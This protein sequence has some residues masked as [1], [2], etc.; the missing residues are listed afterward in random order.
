MYKQ[1]LTLCL[2]GAAFAA[3]GCGP[4]NPGVNTNTNV[5]T[6]VKLDPANMPP[7]LSATPITP[8]ANTPGIP[9]NANPLPIGK[10]PTP[11]IPSPAEL[12]KGVK[13]GTKPTPGI[14]D[15]ETI[16]RQ[17]GQPPLPNANAAPPANGE[18]KKSKRKLGGKI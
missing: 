8:S 10:S 17:M 9:A 4:A 7:G 3:S 2:F 16:R 11:G 18:P 14:P 15:Q 13:P 6:E 1:F 12:K 5:N